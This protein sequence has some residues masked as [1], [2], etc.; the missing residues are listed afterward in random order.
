[1]AIARPARK[2]MNGSGN[3]QAMLRSAMSKAEALL[4]GRKKSKPAPARESAT[5]TAS[6][7]GAVRIRE[8]QKFRVLES[9]PDGPKGEKIFKVILISEG[10]GNRRNKNFYGPEA[11][12]SAVKSFEGKWC[13]LNHQDESESETLPERRVQDK[14][15]YYKNLAIIQ[16]KEG[17]ACAGEL[18]CDL[19]E[20]GVMLAGKVQSALKYKESFPDNE[21][22]YV[23][24]SVNA[25]GSAEPR[26]MTAQGGSSEDNYVTEI[27]EGDSCDLVTTPARGGRGLAVIK[28]SK[29]GAGNP[30]SQE[31]S[32]K[33]KLQA[34][35]AKLAES[36]KSLGDEDK[37]KALTAL[38]KEAEAECKQS[39]DESESWAAQKEGESDE[40]HMA[41]LHGMAKA[42]AKHIGKTAGQGDPAAE[43]DPTTDP[44]DDTDDV[45]AQEAKL[46]G[47]HYKFKGKGAADDDQRKAMFAR[48]NS[49][50]SARYDG[51]CAFIEASGI[52]ADTYGDAEFTHLMKMP[53][54]EARAV[55]AKDAKLAEAIRKQTIKDL[56][57]PAASFHRGISESASDNG[58]GFF[59]AAKKED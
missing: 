15:G 3:V 35:F 34:I 42:V 45:D 36:V 58:A 19:T 54:K 12:S 8:T 31:A 4:K 28:E 48:M 47:G 7:P 49:D 16:V 38:V 40:D 6:R 11:V 10:P 44:A 46:K 24:F 33:K 43:G 20:S 1:M 25:D 32:M 27:T 29:A 9:M 18:H 51:L 21:L 52:P 55:V 22:E 26:D 50:E 13:Y 30:T 53:Y 5:T 56:D 17:S 59:A 2:E 37:K 14:A 41:R 57:L 23:G 39:E